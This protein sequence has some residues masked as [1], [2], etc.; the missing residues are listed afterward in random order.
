MCPHP[1]HP[2]SWKPFSRMAPLS[3]KSRGLW[4]WRSSRHSWVTGWQSTASFTWPMHQRSDRQRVKCTV[5]TPQ[6]DIKLSSDDETLWQ[7]WRQIL[8]QVLGR[9][10]QN[11]T[12]HARFDEEIRKLTTHWCC[13][14]WPDILGL[15]ATRH[16]DL[17]ILPKHRDPHPIAFRAVYGIDSWQRGY[18]NSYD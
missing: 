7:D 10:F 17:R 12:F 6:L 11:S 4:M 16:V 15:N 8:A 1:L 5:D 9:G 13:R 18:N 14:S 3:S 2:Q